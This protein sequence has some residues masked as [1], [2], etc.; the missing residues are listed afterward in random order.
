LDVLRERIEYTKTPAKYGVEIFPAGE[1]RS[2][3]GK[4]LSVVFPAVP[5]RYF[6]NSDETQANFD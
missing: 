1:K 6:Y 4:L 5:G 2:F 3:W